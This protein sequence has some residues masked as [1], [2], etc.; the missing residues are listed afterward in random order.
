MILDIVAIV[1]GIISIGYYIMLKIY[2][3]HIA[4]SIMFFIFGLILVNYGRIEI[5]FKI[6]FWAKLPKII[7]NIITILF[8]I[9][10][11]VFIVIEE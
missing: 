9:G 1:I 4:F 10:L 2:F 5:K 3:G 6:S 11:S 7:R 8:A